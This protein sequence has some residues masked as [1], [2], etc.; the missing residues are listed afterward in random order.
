MPLWE[1]SLRL[2]AV[3]DSLPSIDNLV[4]IEMFFL[5]KIMLFL[6]TTKGMTERNERHEDGGCR[7]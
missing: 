7:E 2:D 1:G 4:R 3:V 6:K 5:F